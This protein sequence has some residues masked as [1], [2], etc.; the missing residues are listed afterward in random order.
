M[1]L[2]LRSSSRSDD[3]AAGLPLL[4]ALLDGCRRPGGGSGELGCAGMALG[5]L[6]SDTRAHATTS[7]LA[8]RR[9]EADRSLGK[10]AAPRLSPQ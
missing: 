3:G 9:Q 7:G 4:P 8:R 1:L 10:V 5:A 6:V 2:R